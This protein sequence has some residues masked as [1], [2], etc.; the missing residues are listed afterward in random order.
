MHETSRNGG[1]DAGWDDG[2]VVVVRQSGNHSVRARG[3][4]GSVEHDHVLVQRRGAGESH[5]GIRLRS[6]GKAS[7]SRHNAA[8]VLLEAVVGDLVQV[9]VA[10]TTQECV[11]VVLVMLPSVPQKD[12]ATGQS[13]AATELVQGI[14]A[15]ALLHGVVDGHLGRTDL[16]DLSL[17]VQELVLV[18][19]SRD[20][21]AIRTRKRGDLLLVGEARLARTGVLRDVDGLD[22]RGGPSIHD[23][24]DSD[25]AGA[26]RVDVCG[27]AGPGGLGQHLAPG[28]TCDER[29]VED[30][31]GIAL[32]VPASEGAT[33][34]LLFSLWPGTP[35]LWVGWDCAT[36]RFVK[37]L[38][39]GQTKLVK[40]A[41]S[42]RRFATSD[43][44][45]SERP[46][47]T[48]AA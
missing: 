14:G 34:H 41:I 29:V 48:R 36:L 11:V 20:H 25:H 39:D 8:D 17:E 24:S 12:V 43:F 2:V 26:D 27:S 32:E 21:L 46:L 38:V 3:S 22:H 5:A 18:A 45:E 40:P 30:V 31:A 10:G 1:R 23:A 47:L 6:S 28:F 15:V 37:N 42:A 35:G 44:W 16:S 9:H 33:C 4:G 13:F 19:K 7:G